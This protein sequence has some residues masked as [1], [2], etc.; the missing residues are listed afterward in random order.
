MHNLWIDGKKL[1]EMGIV[2]SGEG[3]YNAP[4]YDY[5]T[6]AVPGLNGDL[7]QDNGRYKNITVSYPAGITRDFAE[8]AQAA[9]A[10]L[11][12]YG[13]K[14]RRIQDD[15]HPGLY[16][17]GI[18][19]GGIDFEMGFLNRAGETTLAFNCKPQRFLLSGENPITMQS[20]QALFNAWMPT[21][22][23]L[24]VTGNGTLSVGGT[25]ITVSGTSGQ[26]YIDCEIQDAWQGLSNLN[27]NIEVENHEYPVIPAGKSE[28]T[29][30]GITQLKII[31]RWWT[32]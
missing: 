26:F 14:Y 7:I 25:S 6:Q 30:T 12:G 17:M 11:L 22:P 31:P 28:V 23:L 1:Q 29:F 5:E 20:G 3:T 8:N 9:R 2:V 21:K 24:L 27:D 10:F 15:Y 13:A 19:S 16:R 4:E 18:Y 32:L